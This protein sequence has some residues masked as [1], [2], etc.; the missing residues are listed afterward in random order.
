[1]SGERASINLTNQFLIAMPALED[2]LFSR[3][4]VYVCEHTA[5]GAL[6]L[7]LNKPSD[8]V[9]RTLFDKVDL[10]LGRADLREQPV[11]QGG[12]LQTERGFV[13]H[14]APPQ[15]PESALG[16]VYASSI[17]IDGG[18]A[19]TTSRD[20]LEA[21]SAGAG[22]HKVQVTLGYCAWSAGQLEAEL[23]ENAWLT[24]P[25]QPHIIF[26]TPPAQRYDQALA[27]LGMQAWMLSVQAGHA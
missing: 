21:L 15:S 3:S 9:L 7:L 20:V 22:P 27:L 4:L 17:R 26:D 24:V 13:L 25:A 18:L 12:P 2:A 8:S 6:G 5:Q 14:T 16:E 10:P 19:M 11:L 23:A 1:M